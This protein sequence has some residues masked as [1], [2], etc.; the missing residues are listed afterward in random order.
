MEDEGVNKLPVPISFWRLP[1]G[2]LP[3]KEVIL[4][5]LRHFILNAN[6]PPR[7]FSFQTNRL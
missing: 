7:K 2:Q 1:K 3:L 4:Q 5:H 6:P